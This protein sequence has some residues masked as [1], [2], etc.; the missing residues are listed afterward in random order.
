MSRTLSVDATIPENKKL[1]ITLP[2]DVPPGDARVT[3]TVE[4]VSERKRSTGKDLLNSEI[5]GMW[6]DR[7]DIEDSV[8]FA[9]ELR[10]WFPSQP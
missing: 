1:E 8:E 3:V 2:G 4:P 7:T 10:A 6:A 5:F 9:R